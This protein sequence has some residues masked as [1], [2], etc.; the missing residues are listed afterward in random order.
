MENC[1]IKRAHVPPDRGISVVAADFSLFPLSGCTSPEREREGKK[2][3]KS[4]EREKKILK[5]RRIRIRV[6]ESF[7]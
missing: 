1:D 7:T 3:I 4:L 5:T 2:K 6:G